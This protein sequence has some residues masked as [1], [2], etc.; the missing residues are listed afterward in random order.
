MPYLYHA[1][2]NRRQTTVSCL[3]VTC[4]LGTQTSMSY[5]NGNHKNL[6]I[7]MTFIAMRLVQASDQVYSQVPWVW[8]KEIDFTIKSIGHWLRNNI[9]LS[10]IQISITQMPQWLFFNPKNLQIILHTYHIF[11][12]A[13]YIMNVYYLYLMITDSQECN[14]FWVFEYTHFWVSEYIHM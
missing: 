8:A 9:T 1:D 12:Y 10:N 6:L 2:L 13:Q 7:S 3:P 14:C 11:E 5:N 4:T